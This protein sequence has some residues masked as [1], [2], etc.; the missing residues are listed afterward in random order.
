MRRSQ[1]EITDR[2]VIDSIIE[3]SSV[4]R[5]AM[6]DGDRPYVVPMCFGYDGTSLYFHSAKGGMKTDILKK[7]PRVCF[8]FEIECAFEKGDKP[9]QPCDWGMN[10]QTV[11]GFGTA[12]FVDDVAEKRK[13]LD[14]IV[15]Q[16]SSGSFDYPDNMVKAVSVIRVD[17]ESIT[18]KHS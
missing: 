2:A 15:R 9:D 17:V 13:A 6:V 4:C 11:I 14:V 1:Q 3:R 18:G 12:Q 8:E 16:Y 10:Y 5:L 7:N